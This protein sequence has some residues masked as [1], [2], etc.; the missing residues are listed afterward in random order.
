MNP[1]R[2]FRCLSRSA[3]GVWALAT[4]LT[5]PA[6]AQG[7]KASGLLAPA[8]AQSATARAEQPVTADFIVAVVNSEP[9]TNQEVRNRLQRIRAQAAR[10]DQPLPPLDQLRTQVLDALILEKAQLQLAQ[11]LGIRV[12]SGQVDEAERNLA[13][14]NRLTVE[15]LRQELTRQGIDGGEFRQ[16]LRQQLLLQR[17]REREVESRVK[18][19]EADIERFLAQKQDNPGS[20]LNIHLAQILVAVPDNATDA[21]TRQAMERAQSLAARVRKGEDFAALARAHSDAPERQNGGTMGLRPADRYPVLFLHATRTLSVGGVAGPVRSPAG[22]HIL[23]VL[24]KRIAGL[25]E[26]V[27]TETRARH[28]LLRPSANLTE[29]Q[30]VARLTEWRERLIR[31]DADFATVARDISHDSSAADG[32]NLGWVGPGVFVPEF[33]DVMNELRPQAISAPVVSRFGVHLIQVLERRQVELGAREQREQLRMLV[34]E[35][36]LD[37]AYTKWLEDVRARAYVELREPPQ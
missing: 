12:D 36:K 14:Q 17:L 27:T 29:A 18:V 5:M 24:D 9:I 11:E 21:Q 26:P 32:G 34:R 2:S 31:G 3:W 13:R 20:D 28:I 25:P 15:A 6:G 19:S 33:E 10:G 4:A 16:N 8:G 35:S 1:A 7:L 22:F 30:A 37:E 23:K